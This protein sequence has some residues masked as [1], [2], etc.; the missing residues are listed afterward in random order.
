VKGHA[1]AP[2]GINYFLEPGYIYLASEPT[3]ISTVLGS[4]LVVYLHDR[5]RKVAG[6]SHFQ[7]PV[8][9]D[10]EQA[11]ARY[12][13]VAAITLIRMLL[14]DGSKVRH[15][16]AELLGGAHN[17][18][19]SPEDI[20][21]ENISMARKVLDRYGVDIV[22]EDV[23]GIRGR[24]V[25]FNTENNEVAVIRVEKLRSDDWYPYQGSR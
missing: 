6:V 16:E 9:R 1:E 18:E 24:K 3:T 17:A 12:G 4:S 14:D 7:F 25:V 2:T 15:L 8:V 20:G 21:R 22:S 19:L 23:G 13:N 11:T 10:R 5:K